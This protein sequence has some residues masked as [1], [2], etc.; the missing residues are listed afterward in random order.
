M[1][2][3]NSSM[4]RLRVHLDNEADPLHSLFQFQYGAIESLSNSS[5]SKLDLKFQ[6]QYGAIERGINWINPVAPPYFN[7]SMVRLRVVIFNY[8]LCHMVISI[9]VWCDWELNCPAIFELHHIFQFQYGAIESWKLFKLF[10]FL[11]WFQ[12]QYG[13]IESSMCRFCSSKNTTFQ[14]QYGAIERSR[15]KPQHPLQDKISIP[16]WCDWEFCIDTHTYKT[17]FIS[18]PVWCDWEQLAATN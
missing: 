7:S 12:F 2:Y 17:Y 4:V 6:F 14:F 1:T 3:F 5:P 18:I 8:N 16:V 9:P 15:C 10:F 11:I 13:A